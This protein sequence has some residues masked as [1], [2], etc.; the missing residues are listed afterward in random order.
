MPLISKPC[1]KTASFLFSSFDPFVKK[2]TGPKDKQEMSKLL[3]KMKREKKGAKKDI[4]ADAAFIANQRAKEARERWVTTNR[5]EVGSTKRNTVPLLLLYTHTKILRGINL[6]PG[7][8]E[9]T[10][11]R[12]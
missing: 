7:D 10:C 3:H 1:F 2:R 8:Y 4:R 12:S 6:S 9:F 5:F 11:L